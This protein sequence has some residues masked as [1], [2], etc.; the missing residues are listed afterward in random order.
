VC[1]GGAVVDSFGGG[2]KFALLMLCPC[3]TLC[4]ELAES[5][6]VVVVG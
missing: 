5:A 3:R 4:G 6:N 1:C 2:Q